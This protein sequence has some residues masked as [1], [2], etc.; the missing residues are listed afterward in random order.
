MDVARFMFLVVIIFFCRLDQVVDLRKHM[1]FVLLC[2]SRT[3]LN[4]PLCRQTG[5]GVIVLLMRTVAR[6][7]VI[8]LSLLEVPTADRRVCVIANR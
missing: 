8:E 3:I 4:V 1:R 7:S 5:P 6:N 2:I